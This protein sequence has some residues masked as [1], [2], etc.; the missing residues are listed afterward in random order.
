MDL[1]GAPLPGS[2]WPCPAWISGALPGSLRPCTS[3]ISRVLPCLG[4]SG[5]ALPGSQWPCPSWISAA[6]PCMVLSGPGLPGSQQPVPLDLRRLVSRAGRRPICDLTSS[7]FSP[8]R[9]LMSASQQRCARSIT[10]QLPSVS[11]APWSL[12]SGLVWRMLFPQFETPTETQ[13]ISFSLLGIKPAQT[14]W[15]QH[16]N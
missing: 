12:P 10:R 16:R 2:Q 1:S 3:W 11:S 8:S 14:G 7:F 5:P 15:F 4:F 9:V 6:L 13:I